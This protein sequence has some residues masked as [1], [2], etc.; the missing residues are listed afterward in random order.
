MNRA[1]LLQEIRTM[2]FDE[3]YTSWLDKRLTQAE[4]AMG[5]R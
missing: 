3:A 5:T 2:R 1:R 4:A